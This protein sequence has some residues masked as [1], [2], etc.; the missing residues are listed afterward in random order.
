MVL[1][2]SE[3]SGDRDQPPAILSHT[4]DS[5]STS[6]PTLVQSDKGNQMLAV[7]VA[8]SNLTWEGE[9]REAKRVT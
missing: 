4:S 8:A 2:M 6:L 5:A 3:P 9:A 7:S 1:R